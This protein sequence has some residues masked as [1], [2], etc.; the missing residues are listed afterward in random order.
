MKDIVPS[1]LHS[2]SEAGTKGLH[3][4]TLTEA[5]NRRKRTKNGFSRI[6]RYFN[7]QTDRE[8]SGKTNTRSGWGGSMGFNNSAAVPHQQLD[9]LNKGRQKTTMTR[10]GST[11]HVTDLILEMAGDF[12]SMDLVSSYFTIWWWSTE[13]VCHGCQ[14]G[15]TGSR[16]EVR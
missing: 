3:Y 6:D 9:F 15:T 5:W 11:T 16:R 10:T 2:F 8:D 14:C 13:G 7:N 12:W 1:I 4:G